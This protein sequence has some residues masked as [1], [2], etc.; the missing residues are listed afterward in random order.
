MTVISGIILLLV[1]YNIYV[2]LADARLYRLGDAKYTRKLQT[3]I[4]TV[5]FGTCFKTT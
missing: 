4:F 2:Y 5:V 1:I 3:D